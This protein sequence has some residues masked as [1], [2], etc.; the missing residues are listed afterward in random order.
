MVSVSALALTRSPKLRRRF[1]WTVGLLV[2]LA[3]LA[4]GL[5]ALPN[6][7]PEI[8]K[9]SAVAEPEPAAVAPVRDRRVR[10]AAADRRAI[11]DL[12]ARFVPTAVERRHPEA[13]WN[14]VTPALR[15]G[16][17]RAEW[18]SGNLPVFPYQT[19]AKQFDGGWRMHWVRRNEV[20]FDLFLPP[21]RG[22]AYAV[23]YTLVV[24]RFGPRWLVDSAVPSATIAASGQS[25]KVTGQ[26][27]FGPTM[28][29]TDTR[30]RLSALWLV[31]P[32]G[33]TGALIVGLPLGLAL[34]NWR[35][36]RRAL[37]AYQRELLTVD[38]STGHFRRTRA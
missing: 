23:T 6:R 4:A 30:G 5:A 2:A 18:A 21:T 29:T 32:L 36:H 12:L 35:R 22:A 37:A 31:V 20:S 34:V 7:S 26:G 17:T 19:R 15:R 8:P 16:L 38:V 11:G 24:R 10:L 3:A 28:G 33:L 13:A 27:D 25:P 1:A 14:L 9:A